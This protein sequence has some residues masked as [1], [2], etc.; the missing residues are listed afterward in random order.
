VALPKIFSLNILKNNGNIL[1]YFKNL[2][3]I[4]LFLGKK[5]LFKIEKFGV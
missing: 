3:M 5:F 2:K 1:V 4:R